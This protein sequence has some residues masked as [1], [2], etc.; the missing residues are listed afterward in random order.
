MVVAEAGSVVEG[1]VD[2]EPAKYVAVVD[3]IVQDFS[4]LAEEMAGVALCYV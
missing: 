4:D 2:A 3:E 1:T